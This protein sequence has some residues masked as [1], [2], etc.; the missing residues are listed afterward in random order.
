MK[1]RS[2]FNYKIKEYIMLNCPKKDKVFVI[3][4]ISNID[5]IENINQEKKQLFSKKKKGA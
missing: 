5:N 1:K 2:Y 3:I 4:D